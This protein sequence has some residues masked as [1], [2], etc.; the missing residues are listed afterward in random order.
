MTEPLYPSNRYQLWSD[1]IEKSSRQ[2]LKAVTWCLGDKPCKTLAGPITWTD[3][4][5]GR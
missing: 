5:K 4:R 1:S 2:R 3:K